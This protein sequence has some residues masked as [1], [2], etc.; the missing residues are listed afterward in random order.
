M[1]AE[2]LLDYAVPMLYG[3]PTVEP[4]MPI[5]WLVA[6]ARGSP[7][8]CDVLPLV[9]PCYWD[10]AQQGWASPPM[11]A[12]CA[13]NFI[14]AGAGGVY[15]WGHRWP[16]GEVQR[17]T[18]RMLGDDAAL[19][20]ADKHYVLSRQLGEVA[21][22]VGYA[23]ALPRTLTAA[24]GTGAAAHRFVFEVAEG[25]EGAARV[26]LRLRIL[27]LVSA[28][29]L[30]V[31][32]NGVTLADDGAAGRSRQRHEFGSGKNPYKS[33][34]WLFE[35]EAG[36]A[37]RGQNELGV[38]LV[39][40]AEGLG[41]ALTLQDVELLVVHKAARRGKEAHEWYQHAPARM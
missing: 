16:L 25:V 7:R 14:A 26:V 33:L 37:R 17:R 36:V 2:G 18:I 1:L 11:L 12:A 24:G 4:M 31:E 28:D 19:R 9:S 21:E 3:Y 30:A 41:G 23:T 8:A 39:R 35:L 22:A 10:G 40:R 32:L 5:A 13:A 27:E 38:R 34:W 6:A 20:R 29:V 15:T